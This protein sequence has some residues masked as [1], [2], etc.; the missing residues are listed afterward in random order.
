MRGIIFKRG[1]TYTIVYD[2]KDA[3]GKRKQKWEGG[4]KTKRE[5]EA[6]LNERVSGTNIG[7][8]PSRLTVEKYLREWCKI[9]KDKLA[10][11]SWNRYK[12]A[13]ELWLIPYL[14]SIKLSRLTAIDIDNAYTEIRK[15]PRKDG[16]TGSLSAVTIGLIHGVLRK[17]L[18]DAVRKKIIGYNPVYG[19]D[20]PRRQYIDYKIISADDINRI[21][22]HIQGTVYYAP[23]A[24]A[25]L[26]GMRLGEVLGLRWQD[27]DIE[28]QVLYVRLALKR[29]GAG[30]LVH[31][32]PKTEKSRRA[33]KIGEQTIS[34]LN[35]QKE[36]QEQWRIQSAEQWVDTGLVC[37]RVNGEA[38][39]PSSVSSR[40]YGIMKSLGIEG[41]MHSLRHSHATLLL[42]AGVNIKIVQERLG[43]STIQT[44]ADV[45][46][47]VQPDMQENAVYAIEEIIRDTSK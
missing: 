5:A 17:A 22:N 32:Q 43:H 31:E 39:N 1:R 16:R 33:I 30:V 36:L 20:L 21:I 12:L 28:K 10:P 23:V 2:T 14:G 25:A 46:S 38:L 11:T 6:A 8:A 34:I 42:Q 7:V 13:I 29:I 19:A 18:N 9:Q 27:I 3:Q 26:T 40:V 47:H 45:Y 41:N 44:T 37:T 4:F 24:L 15:A 35:K